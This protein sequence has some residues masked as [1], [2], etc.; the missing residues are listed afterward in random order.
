MRED[1]PFTGLKA[2]RLYWK[3]DLG[4]AFS[5]ALVA[6]PLA[7]GISLASGAPPMSGVMTAVIGGLLTTFIRGSYV[8][9]NGP[10]NGV[11]VVVLGGIALLSDANGAGGFKYVLAAIVVSGCIQMILGAFRLGKLGDLIPSSVINGM[12]ATIGVIIFAKQY[13]VSLGT[14]YGTGSALDAVLEIPESLLHLNPAITLIS[15]ISLLIMILH[16]KIKLKFLYSIPAPLQVMVVSIIAVYVINFLGGPDKQIMGQPFYVDQSSLIH[17]PDNILD[18]IIY[19]DFGK[20]DQLEFWTVVLLIT[21]VTT[22]ESLISTKA[23]DKLDP[24]KRRTNLNKDLFGMGASTVVSGFLGGLPIITVIVRSSVNIQHNAKSKWSNFYHGLILLILVLLLPNIIKTIPLAALATILVFTGY[25]LASPRVFKNALMKGWEQLAILSVTLVA[26]LSLNILWGILIGISATLI[27]QWIRSDLTFG[28]FWKH[29]RGTEINVTEESGNTVHLDI[30]GIANFAILLRL[31]NS[32]QGLSADKNFIVNFSH[33][34]L[35]DS[36]VLEFIDEHREKYF[37]KGHFEYVGL[38]VHQTSSPH[39]LALHVLEKPM[40]KR[41]TGRQNELFHYAI[42]NQYEYKAELDWNIKYFESFNFFEF[43]LLEYHRNRLRGQFNENIKWQIS[44]LTYNDGVFLAQEESH[45]TVMII[46][47]K[48]NVSAFDISKED[49][50]KIKTF[51]RDP[52]KP[53]IPSGIRQLAEFFSNNPSYY[54]E[55]LENKILI[56]RKQRL[57]SSKEIIELHNFV[58]QCCEII[59]ESTSTISQLKSYI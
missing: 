31:I 29:M 36:T 19:P 54:I 39:P 40:Q 6:L 14:S 17:I 21:L 37:T 7:L 38:D 58:E 26:S 59:P 22:I 32:L 49:I 30:K 34:K 1:I 18:N 45:I 25:K 53:G 43:H 16:S 27:I 33:T 44:D 47:L 5:V 48:F 35:V 50:R 55:G 9:I 42:A 11:I 23:V 8:G 52:N 20:I 15:I 2:L 10:A 24:Y 51:V 56:F 46:F 41:L 28:T 3:D 12:L 13:H 57:L 4:A